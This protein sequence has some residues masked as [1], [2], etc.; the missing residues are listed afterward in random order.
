MA[1]RR[2]ES[3]GKRS[4]KTSSKDFALRLAVSMTDLTTLEGKD[5]PEKV[6]SLCRK[7]I[8]PAPNL[9]RQLE[10]AGLRPAPRAD[11]ATLL[12]RVTFALIGL[13]PTPG[14][15]DAFVGDEAP[16]AYERVVERLREL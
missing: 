4:I 15:V 16:D 7:A 12:R 13:P 6:R 1:A 9:S 3:F 5:S 11:R 2:A 14:E 8:S 10:A